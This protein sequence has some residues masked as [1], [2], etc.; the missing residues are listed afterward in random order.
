M[1]DLLSEGE[2]MQHRPCTY[3][4]Q[5]IFP[6]KVRRYYLFFGPLTSLG[7]LVFSIFM[8]SVACSQESSRLPCFFVGALFTILALIYSIVW[9]TNLTFIYARYSVDEFVVNNQIGSHQVSVQLAGSTQETVEFEFSLGY[10]KVTARYAIVSR[11]KITDEI[12][13]YDNLYKKAKCIWIS[14]CAII[15]KAED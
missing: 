11:K 7:L 15:P 2:F 13:K 5:Y 1:V 4:R 12:N 14:N 6:S 10:S 9:C 3:T 8:Y